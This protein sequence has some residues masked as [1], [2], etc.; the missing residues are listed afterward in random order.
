[1]TSNIGAELIKRD[2]TLGFAVRDDEAKT[3]ERDYDKMKDKVLG[4]LKKAF[5]PEFLNR[6]DN[7]VVFHALTKEHL[8]QIVDLEL[9][10]IRDQLAEKGVSLEVTEA[11]K[12][13]LCEKGYDP[14]FGARPLRRVIQD[15][16]EDPLS[17]WVLEGRFQEGDTAVIDR[18]EDQIVVKPVALAESLP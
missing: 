17:E 8:R 3:A 13:L 10:T 14:T 16:V 4:E 18:D 12:D 1:M 9:M 11:A 2:M 5:R 7:T 6:I 15:M